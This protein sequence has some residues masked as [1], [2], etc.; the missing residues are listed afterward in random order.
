MKLDNPK[1]TIL[2][3]T[4]DRYNTLKPLCKYLNEK[5]GDFQVIISDNSSDNSPMNEFIKVLNDKFIYIHEHAPLSMRDNCDRGIH[6]ASG[7]YI[8]MIGDDDGV[9]LDN[10]FSCIETLDA[11]NM[12]FALSQNCKY[13]WPNL[14]VRLFG[15][16]NYGLLRHFDKKDKNEII[17]S[18]NELAKVADLGGV[19]IGN[20]PRLYQGLVKTKYLKESIEKYKTMFLAPMP[21]MSS[22][23]LLGAITNKGIIFHTPFIINGVSSKSGGGLGAA[24]KHKGTLEQGYGLTEKDVKEWPNNVPKFWSGGTVWASSFLIT[25]NKM[26]V[27]DTI[28]FN[29]KALISYCIV[30]HY[31]LILAMNEDNITRNMSLTLFLKVCSKFKQRFL[32]L[33]NNFNYYTFSKK[34]KFNDIY[35]VLNFIEK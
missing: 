27:L 24:G 14:K 8:T 11:E 1:L 22:S 18:K 34:N 6:L 15:K 17:F 9:I 3:P 21:D 10:I 19:S 29:D 20:L 13:M 30:F 26:N 28:K 25:L 16:K 23:T 31:K 35:E 33:I 12:D 7:Q 4:K 32:S 2:I 5:E